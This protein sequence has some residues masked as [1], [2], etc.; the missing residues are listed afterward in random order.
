MKLL[1]R[2]LRRWWRGPPRCPVTMPQPPAGWIP[3][4]TQHPHLWLPTPPA[5]WRW[6]KPAYFHPL[7]S[8]D[9]SRPP[10]RVI[11]KY[12]DGAA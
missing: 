1:Y 2:R 5:G 12:P 6:K 3:R 4:P 10:P 7:S 8:N 11:C 9:N